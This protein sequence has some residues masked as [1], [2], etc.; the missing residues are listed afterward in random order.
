MFQRDRRTDRQT[1]SQTDAQSANHRSPLV[2]PQTLLLFYSRKRKATTPRA[3][4]KKTLLEESVALLQL[5]DT[6]DNPLQKANPDEILTKRIARIVKICGR[7]ENII[8]GCVT[9]EKFIKS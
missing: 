5:K 3:V 6:P 8:P 1:D 7:N 9:K 4:S 2:K